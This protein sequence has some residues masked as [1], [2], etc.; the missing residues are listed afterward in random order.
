MCCSALW[1]LSPEWAAAR[2]RELGAG[3]VIPSA[4][5]GAL[6]VQQDAPLLQTAESELDFLASHLALRK[7]SLCFKPCLRFLLF[8]AL[9]PVWGK[10]S[11]GRTADM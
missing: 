6:R 9:G 7:G 10:C 5:E 3:S 8:V 1:G 4:G 2:L 11:L